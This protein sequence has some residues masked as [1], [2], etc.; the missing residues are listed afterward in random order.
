[1]KTKAILSIIAVAAMMVACGNHSQVKNTET[2]QMADT[3]SPSL[4][5]CDVTLSGIHFTKALNGADS[6]VAEENG[7]ISFR[8]GEK[9]DMFNDPNGK[10]PNNTAPI[11]LTEVDNTKPFTFMARIQPGF[12]KTDTY[13]A[14]VLYL[15]ENI[16]HWQKF[17]FEQDERGNHRVVTVRTI[18]T[19]DD[20]NSE[21]INDQD[22][23][24]YKYSSDTKTVAS[25]FSRDGKTW[26]MV[27]LYKNDFPKTFYV[28]IS[29]QCP[30]GKGNMSK[31]SELSMKQESIKDFRLGI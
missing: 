18:G 5:D 26:T 13:N 22:Y 29:S 25:Y 10:L 16:N 11:L 6:L 8:S 3:L 21:V 30:Q 14:G 27:R 24:Y 2:A 28:G 20:N 9:K 12:T 17:C 1:M 15:Y 19:S 23:V 7:V 31:F 4:T